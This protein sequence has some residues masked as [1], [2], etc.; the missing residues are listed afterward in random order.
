[1]LYYSK[2]RTKTKQLPSFPNSKSLINEI[3]FHLLLSSLFSLWGHFPYGG[4]VALLGGEFLKKQV[5][6]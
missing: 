6:K 1:M 2:T 5:I 4:G 3:E